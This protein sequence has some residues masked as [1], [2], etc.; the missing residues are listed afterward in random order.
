[1]TI[2]WSYLICLAISIVI[3]FYIFYPKIENFFL[4]FPQ[5]SFDLTPED[6]G[7]DYKD[8][9]LKTEDG[10]NLHGWFFPLDKNSPLVLFFHGN[11]GN[12]SHRLDNVRLI[13]DKKIQV[14]IFDYRGY[15]KSS[16]KPSENGLY[17]DGLA[18]WDYL[19]HKEKIL[20]D[21]IV[22]FGRSLGAA[23]AIDVALKRQVR[24]IIIESGFTSIKDMAKT[25]FLFSLLS[26]S[27]PGHYNNLE[28]I[29]LIKIPKLIIHGVNDE[30]VPFF[31]GE[32]LFNSSKEP[33]YFFPIKRAGHNDTYVVGGIRYFQI[34]EAFIMNSKI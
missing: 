24:S 13:L 30:L 7:I 25:I 16:G 19:V 15:G 21:N 10:E 8:V 2:K 12:I 4:F 20:P 3:F 32:K 33:K 27:L 31:M 1:M 17:K 23:A 34:L 5:T 6:L 26:F 9:H 14:F 11:A 22:L 28:K 29:S 18:A